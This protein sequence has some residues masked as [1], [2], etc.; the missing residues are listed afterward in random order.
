MCQTETIDAIPCCKQNARL[1]VNSLS[2]INDGRNINGVINWMHVTLCFKMWHVSV[3]LWKKCHFNCT[4]ETWNQ[5][6]K[7]ACR[8]LF[9]NVQ[10]LCLIHYLFKITCDVIQIRHFG[11]AISC[12]EM[13]NF[14]QWVHW[15]CGFELDLRAENNQ[16]HQGL[17][18][19]IIVDCQAF[20][21]SLDVTCPLK[22]SKHGK[23]SYVNGTT[24]GLIVAWGISLH[25]GMLW[26]HHCARINTTA[27]SKPKRCSC[28]LSR[29]LLFAKTCG[30]VWQQL[31]LIL[32]HSSVHRRAWA[33][34]KISAWNMAFVL[35]V[36]FGHCD[37]VDS[38]AVSAL[39][40]RTTSTSFCHCCSMTNY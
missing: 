25:H 34:N 7:F 15:F 26:H 40:R 32:V 2:W 5:G 35:S 21:A 30:V 16:I 23:I 37:Q 33:L 11:L 10:F 22:W 24:W 28:C 19:N 31:C 36:N 38:V 39:T 6:C 27:C 20:F 4:N 3:L 13:Q 1:F 18:W 29:A 8:Q 14:N 12:F 17:A 9:W